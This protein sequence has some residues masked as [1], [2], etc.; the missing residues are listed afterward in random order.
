MENVCFVLGA[1][2]SPGT[3]TKQKLVLAAPHLGQ[4][5]RKLYINSSACLY[6][7]PTVALLAFIY[8]SVHQVNKVHSVNQLNQGHL[9]H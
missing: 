4:A 5:Q 8:I 6:R 9:L 1:N 3:V 7:Y 2:N